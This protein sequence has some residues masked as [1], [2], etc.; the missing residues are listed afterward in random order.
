MEQEKD[1]TLVAKKLNLFQFQVEEMERDM[2]KY[3]HSSINGFVRM[4]IAH[5]YDTMADKPKA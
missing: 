1:M 2:R 3:G 5:F 4:A